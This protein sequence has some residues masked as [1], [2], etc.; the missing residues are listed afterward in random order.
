MAAEG[1]VPLT[2]L[3]APDVTGRLEMLERRGGL[4]SIVD[5]VQALPQAQPSALYTKVS[6]H[7][8]AVQSSIV[9][10]CVLCSSYLIWQDIQ[11]SLQQIFLQQP[12]GWQW[13][14][15]TWASR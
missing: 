13:L 11:T 10:H 14:D 8:A 1:V 5:E 7:P 2:D 3:E 12:L 4:F 9:T 15:T 6:I